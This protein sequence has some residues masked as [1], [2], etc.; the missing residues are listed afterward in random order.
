MKIIRKHSVSNLVFSM[1]F[2]IDYN[3]GEKYWTETRPAWV[4]AALAIEGLDVDPN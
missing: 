2:T 3:Q 4:M 1:E